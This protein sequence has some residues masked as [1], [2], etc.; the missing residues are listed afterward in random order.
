MVST[1]ISFKTRLFREDNK[2]FGRH[3]IEGLKI[4]CINATRFL[5][6]LGVRVLYNTRFEENYFLYRYVSVLFIV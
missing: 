4:C 1:L 6:T 2:K 3:C 5:G